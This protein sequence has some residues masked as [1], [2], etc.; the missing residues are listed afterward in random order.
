MVK[1]KTKHIVFITKKEEDNIHIV[2]YLYD[3]KDLTSTLHLTLK[4]TLNLFQLYIDFK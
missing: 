3:T 1:A 2:L 4:L